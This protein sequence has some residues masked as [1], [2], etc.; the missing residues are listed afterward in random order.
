[1]SLAQRASRELIWQT[2]VNLVLKPLF[3]FNVRVRVLT[4]EPVPHDRGFIFA[5][6]HV[7]HFDPPLLTLNFSRKIDWIAVAELFHGKILKALFASLNV[8]PVDRSGADRTALR[9]AAKRLKEGRVVGI[10]PEG[11]IR[12]GAASI[13]NGAAMKPGFALLSTL[14]DAPI[15]PCVILGSERLYNGKNWLPWRRIDVWIAHG[16]MI[17]PPAD[18]AGEEKRR[19]IKEA[20]Q[21]EIARLRDRLVEHYQLSEADLP[22]SP[23]QRMAEP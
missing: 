18:L 4:D 7:S 1:M 16:R 14:A 11:G 5:S 17:E 13:V 9:T 3:F 10:F 19:H 2:C 22:H 6:N 8:I 21:G 12:D 23:Q 15:L 20:F